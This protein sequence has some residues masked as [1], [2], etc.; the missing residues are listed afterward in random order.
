MDKVLHKIANLISG[1]A[2]RFIIGISGHGASGKTTF[3]HNLLKLLQRD[4]VNYINTDPYIVESSLRKYTSI[5]YE[6]KNAH[7]H[8][9]VTAC[10][11]AAH[12][13]SALERDIHMLRDGLDFYTIGTDYTKS[14]FI[15]SQNKI[16]IVEGMSVAFTDPN[17][18]D[19][20]IYLYTDGETELVRRSIRDV[21]ERGTDI[22]YLR[23]SHEQRRMQYELFMHSY[24]HKFDIVLKNSNEEY[25]LEKGTL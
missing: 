21:S 9:K 3:A 24:H 7:Y 22:N 5:D 17:L 18:Y 6:Y 11:P 23:K 2:N 10:H 13:I 8:D 20:K 25:V 15:S 1:E 14:M 19:L 16:N 12:H 4:D